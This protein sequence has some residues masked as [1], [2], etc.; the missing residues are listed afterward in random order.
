MTAAINGKRRPPHDLS[1]SPRLPLSP[2][3][4]LRLCLSS[5][6]PFAHLLQAHALEHPHSPLPPPLFFAAAGEGQTPPPF[7]LASLVRQRLIELVLPQVFVLGA[8]R[9]RAPTTP[10]HRPTCRRCQAPLPS[11]PLRLRARLALLRTVRNNPR[12]ISLL[13]VHFGALT[14]SPE[15]PRRPLPVPAADE[16]QSTP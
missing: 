13:L 7:F 2:S 6:L 4:Y 14:S 11:H 16:A 5:C 1:A 15:R 3:G 9:S 8:C 10:E 12:S